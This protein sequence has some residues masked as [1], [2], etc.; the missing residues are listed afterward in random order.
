MASVTSRQPTTPGRIRLLPVLVA[1]QIAAGEVVERPASVVKELVE[2]AIDA[3]ASRITVE[4]DVGGIELIR[5]VDD[6]CGIEADDLV[7]SVSPH[8]TSKIADAEDLDKVASLG[9]RG[10][11]LASVASVS[12]LTIRSRTHG[13]ESAHELAFDPSADAVPA[14]RP[15][16]GRGGTTVEVRNLFFNTPARRKFLKTPST[17]RSRCFE[18]VRQIALSRPDIGFVVRNDDTTLLDVEA[19]DSARDRAIA[20][21]GKELERELLE[22]EFDAFDDEHGVLVWGLVGTPAIV[23]ASSK[24][25]FVYVNGRCVR[26]RVIQHA[27]SEAYRGLIEPGRHPTAVLMIELAPDRVDVN[28]HPAKAEVRFRD[29]SRVHSAVFRAVKE[30]LQKA[31]LTPR[32]LPVRSGFSSPSALMP[33]G[34]HPSSHAQSFVDFLR[35]PAGQQTSRLSY[36]TLRQAVEGDARATIDAPADAGSDAPANAGRT[37]DADLGLH[38]PASFID[39]PPPDAFVPRPQRGILQVHRSYLVTQ[40]EHGVVIVDQ[41]ALHER[42][43]F[44]YLMQ[45][46]ERSD[47]ESQPLLAPEVLEVSPD[48]VVSLDDLQPLLTRLGIELRAMGPRSIAIGAFPSLLFERKVEMVPFVRELLDKVTESAFAPDSEDALRDVLDMMSCKA[49]IKAGD[50]MSETELQRLIELRD[51]V[52]RSSSCPHGRPT[53]VRLTIEELEKLFHRR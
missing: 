2:N 34:G 45:R 29:S 27:L 37:D 14:I 3:G 9:F 12:R 46:V 8:A 33:T 24:E 39:R 4:L 20:I 21:L 48:Q 42:V 23:R 52:D 5:V 38:E 7:L 30:A 16:S 53:S 15:A 25:Q 50:H 17:E 11:A 6:G 41:H 40:D 22:A 47:L 32:A 26:D 36:E 13:S 1:N 43:M 18:V 51:E 28:V 49:A 31:D 19:A 10:E 44:E 35:A